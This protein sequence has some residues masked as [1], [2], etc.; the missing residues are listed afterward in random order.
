VVSDAGLREIVR[1]DSFMSFSG[2]DLTR[3]TDMVDSRATVAVAVSESVLQ[4]QGH[5]CF[6]RRAAF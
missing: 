3:V 2:T 5:L 4:A 1:A 6:P